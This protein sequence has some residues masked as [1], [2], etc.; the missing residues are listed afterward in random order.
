MDTLGRD[1]LQTGKGIFK[2]KDTIDIP[3]LAMIDDV[4][5]MAHCGD[6][7]I[8]LNAI[9]NAKM[10]SKKLRLGEDKCFK[11]HICKKGGKCNQIL[12]VHEANMKDASTVTYLGDVV[13]DA[14][15]ID[16]TIDQRGQKA[17]GITTQIAS[18]LSSISLGNFHF[19]IALVMRDALFTNSI[20][21]NAEVWHNVKLYHV[22][23]LESYDVNL[24]RKILNAHSKTANEAFFLELG[25]YPLRF[26]LSKRRCMY[27]WHIVHRDTDELIWK[28]YEA[29]KC[30]PNKGDWYEILQTER[31]SLNI[32]VTDDEISKMSKTKF[33]S[34]VEKKIRENV[35][36]YLN[37]LAASH[38]KSEFIV[39]DKFE[40]KRYF[41]D[42]RFS[43]EDVQLLFALRTRMINCKS[44]FKNQF[45]TNL[46]CRI[47]KVDG[48][49]ED[50]DHILICPELTDG[51]SEV[52]FTDVFGDVN[53]QY[54]AVQMYKKIIRRRRVYL[55][56]LDST[57]H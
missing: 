4:M 54:N 11:L 20:M 25:R 30:N 37:K 5:G 17:E 24:L 39:G 21:T 36:K 33:K 6:A 16:A 22:Q 12:K 56:I 43:R 34:L 52:Q 40:K 49:I 14:G 47:C 35:E 45:G 44:N 2:Y 29:Q 1:A 13:S 19:D 27:L 38:S 23:S 3:S 31:T 51:Q 15:T 10:E 18:I 26:V 9:I 46:I 42:R 7:S 57:D 28:I 53:S 50:E 41:S 48:S 32:L 8:E 55:E